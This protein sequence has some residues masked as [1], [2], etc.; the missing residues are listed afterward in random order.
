MDKFGGPRFS[1]GHAVND[2]VSSVANKTPVDLRFFK[3]AGFSGE[4]FQ[5]PSGEFFSA[6]GKQNDSFGSVGS[7][8]H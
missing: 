1:N 2:N 4:Q 6:V 7:I 8:S 5:L 3:D